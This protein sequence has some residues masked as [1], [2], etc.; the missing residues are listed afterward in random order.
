MVRCLKNGKAPTN[1]RNLNKALFSIIPP[2]TS[3]FSRSIA[4]FCRNLLDIE[5]LDQQAW[6]IPPTLE[7]LQY[8]KDLPL[9][10]T[11]HPIKSQTKLSPIKPDV[12]HGISS[13]CRNLFL[14]DIKSTNFP[15]ATFSWHE[16]WESHWNQLFAALIMKHWN[17]G[18]KHNAFANFPMN[19]SHNTPSNFR[20][21]LKRWF[22]G[23]S[24][25]I[26]Q[27]KYTKEA[28]EKKAY[29]VAQSGLL[30]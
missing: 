21:V 23:K 27:G 28:M 24:S 16:P 3:H 19:L 2:P 14:R 9:S 6:Q 22:M 5:T 18:H 15:Q 17:H 4:S 29:Q 20:A 1:D 11:S 13:D 25:D 8:V 12:L 7:Q 30:A 26:R 10:I